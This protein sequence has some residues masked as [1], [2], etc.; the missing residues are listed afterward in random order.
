MRRREF[1][2]LFGGAAVWSLGAARAQPRVEDYENYRTRLIDLYYDNQLETLVSRFQPNRKTV[3]LLPGEWDR[4]SSE[5]GKPFRRGRTFPRT[6]SGSMS[7][8]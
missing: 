4:N 7:E 3:I 6:W 8:S 1:I 2:R 5:P